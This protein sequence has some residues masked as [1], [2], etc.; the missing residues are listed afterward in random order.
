MKVHDSGKVIS[1]E[2][3]EVI[4]MVNKNTK[5]TQ[6]LVKY[7][8]LVKIFKPYTFEYLTDDN[9]TIGDV[10][11]NNNLDVEGFVREINELLKEEMDR[12][13]G[14][15]N[16]SELLDIIDETYFEDLIDEMPVLRIYV[17]KFIDSKDTAGSEVIEV[18]ESLVEQV[19]S[20]IE[21]AKETLHPLV[22]AVIDGQ[23]KNT[24]TPSV[25]KQAEL[26]RGTLDVLKRLREKTNH[27]VA[28]DATAETQFL[29]S[30]MNAIED[31]ILDMLLLE[32]KTYKEVMK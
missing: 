8:D 3:E 21:Y 1:S 9:L 6:V 20:Y 5:I 14:E 22:K 18:F 26:K 7:A 23:D 4:F 19:N 30:R 17:E 12:D 28:E 24:I 2:L 15:K 10:A 11:T 31:T 16:V 27:Y 29:Y 13:L 25:T 32:T